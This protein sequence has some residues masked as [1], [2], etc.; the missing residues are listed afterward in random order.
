[1]KLATFIE[2]QACRIDGEDQPNIHIIMEHPEPKIL[3]LRPATLQDKGK[4]FNWLTNSNLTGEMLGP[5]N[6]PEI[7]IPTW[8]EFDNDYLDHYF[9]GSQPFKG[10][11]FI[12]I[13]DGQEIGQINYNE[14]D[15]ASKSTE[16]DI[17]LADREFTGKGHGTEAIKLLCNYLDK[18]LECKTFYIAPS[19]RNPN[20]IKSYKKAGFVETDIIPDYFTPDYDD[21]VV[22]M[23]T[24]L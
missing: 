7:P 10:Q 22:M 21:T 5:P 20:A 6:F 12:I 11:C 17:W 13:Y 14:I 23:K 4:I 3:T 8:K 2:K 24:L 9:D 1:M 19:R 15:T 16:L 18:H